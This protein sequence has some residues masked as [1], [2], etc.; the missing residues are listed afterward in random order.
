MKPHRLTITAFGPYADTVEI[1]FDR[2]ADE[3]LFLIHGDTGAGK[4]YLLDALCFAL[5]GKV[6]GARDETHLKSDHAAADAVPGVRLEFSVHGNRYVVHREPAHERPKKKGAGTTSQAARA[7]IARVDGAAEIPMATARAEVDSIIA[8]LIGLTVSQFTQVMLLPQGNFAEVLR[9]KADQRENLLKTLFDTHLYERISAWL[10]DEARTA[11]AAVTNQI[12]TLEVLRNQAAH[13]W[14]PFVPDGEEAIAPADDAAFAVLE[15]RIDGLAGA[16]ETA[17]AAAKAEH[18]R[19]VTAQQEVDA[20]AARWDRRAQA[21]AAADKLETERAGVDADRNT[22]RSAE[23]AEPLRSSIAA[24]DNAERALT[25]LR[26]AAAS[27]LRAAEAARTAAPIV[28][29]AVRALTFDSLP[30]AAAL[31]AAMTGT[32]TTTTRLEEAAKRLDEAARLAEQ[33]TSAA[34]KATK[35]EHTKRTDTERLDAARTDR[36]AAETA[37]LAARGAGDRLDGLRQAATRTRAVADAAQDLV[38]ARAEEGRAKQVLVTATDAELAAKGHA[39]E[40]RN[41]QLAGMAARLA[42]ELTEGAPCPVCG[43]AEHP[44]PARPAADAV[45]D[46]MI[47]AADEASAGAETSRQRATEAVR[48]A[49]AETAGLVAR[50]GDDTD[51]VAAEAAA[52]AAE[53]EL[54]DATRIA[55]GLAD[56]EQRLQMIDATIDVL[57][58]RIA[59]ADAE[60]AAARAEAERLDQ[61]AAD[62]REAVKREVGADLDLAAAL[63]ALGSLAA[64]LEALQGDGDAMT[65]SEAA[66]TQARTRL[67]EDLAQSPFTDVTA[68]GTALRDEKSRSTL[69]RRIKDFDTEV[70]RNAGVLAEPDLTGLPD[71]RPDTTSAAAATR[72]ADTARDAATRFAQQAGRART[73]ISRLAEAHRSGTIALGADRDRAELLQTIANRCSGRSAPRVSL[74]RWVLQAYL[75]DICIYANQRLTTMSSGRY[76][77]CT[78]NDERH[79][80]MVAG[81][82]LDV[83]DTYTGELRDVS[84]L[85]GG[86]T[87][88]ASLALALG[89]A[90]AVQAHAGGFRIE[91]LFIDEGF[92]TLD[93]DSLDAAMEELDRLRDGGRLIGI[94]SHVGTLRERIRTGIEVTKGPRGSR[95]RIGTTAEA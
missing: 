60:V 55:G 30:P 70:A 43:S 49:E 33:A 10:D 56:A 72:A 52:R 12:Q 21:Q 74:Q 89:V 86:E 75:D 22:L 88:Q 48:R 4:T 6:A 7:S 68:V 62:R 50:A 23:A 36:T 39:L 5:Y 57:S 37:V 79:G 25:T 64:T 58:N 61:Q 20:V 90:D 19:C 15:E 11:Q 35:V 1:D 66:A 80:G 87:F 3:G 45:D 73:E 92:G 32:V 27:R 93:P 17:A 38:G 34:A 14:K 85:S 91:A 95:V 82:G 16:A 77:L 46:D 9:A 44:A 76:H 67:A 94:I 69:A 40:L 13:E 53:A 31:Q 83:R 59:G 41:R 63:R 51:P 47:A 8:E 78:R 42:T 2:L 81:L 26:E 65:R 24:V 18:D 54:H 28:P 29:D 84:T 71:D